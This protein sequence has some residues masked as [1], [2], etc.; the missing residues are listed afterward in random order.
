MRAG[1][2]TLSFGNASGVDR[3]AEPDA[4]QAER[5]AVCGPAAGGPRRG[6]PRRRATGR[7]WRCGHRPT[8]R[9]TSRS[10]GRIRRSAGSSTRIRR[11]PRRGRRPA[12]RSRR[13]GRPT[14]TISTGPSRSRASSATQEVAGD[15]EAATGAVIVEALDAAGLDAVEMP[16]VL[17]AS[18][19]PFTWGPDPAAAADNAIAL[20]AVAAMAIETLALDPDAKPMAASLLDRHYQPQARG[21]RLL[22]AAPVT[23][24]ERS[25]PPRSRGCMGRATSGSAARRSP[26]PGPGRGPRPGHGGRPVR[27][28]PALV[29]RG[30]DRRRRPGASARARPRVRRRHPRRA[31]GRGARRRRPGRPV[32]PVRTV[33]P[34]SLQ[35]LHRDAVRGFRHDRRRAPLGHALAEPPAPSRCRTRSVT[36]RPPCSSRSAS[37]STRSISAPIAVGA[38]AGVY[39]CGPLGLLL[40]QLLRLSGASV[41]VATDRLAHRVAAARAIGATHGF[42]VG[43]RRR[44]IPPTVGAGRPRRAG[45]RRL[46]GRR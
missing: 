24:V 4:H 44:P 38:R 34:R 31:A 2:V 40:I 43:A 14:P 25:A 42:V 32:R 26:T 27:L 6:R 19:G 23:A 41:I 28:G 39:G 11:P 21:D 10:T 13:S 9:P 45:R 36:T 22:R 12:G 15:Y 3:D 37:R 46:R 5:R 7:R 35:R 20:E 33:P 18:H 17:V 16:A 8:R 29:S 1:L 30:R